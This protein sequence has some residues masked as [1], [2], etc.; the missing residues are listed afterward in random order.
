MEMNDLSFKVLKMNSIQGSLSLHC[1]DYGEFHKTLHVVNIHA[2]Q[3][4][5]RQYTCMPV[6]MSSIYM[7]DCIHVVNLH[8]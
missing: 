8:E 2:C 7:H 5:C 3:C 6:Y 1:I 4:T